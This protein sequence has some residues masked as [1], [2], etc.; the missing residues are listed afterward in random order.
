MRRTA[1]V[2]AFL[3]AA[4]PAAAA[5]VAP[6]QA[7]VPTCMGEPATIVGGR[8][9]DPLVG[10]P[11]RDVIVGG[12]GF[13]EIRGRGGDDLICG[14]RGRDTLY[15]GAG[16][17]VI[18]VGPADGSFADLVSYKTAGRGIHADLR[19][20]VV[21]GQGRDRILG[22]QLEL[23]GSHHDDVLIGGPSTVAIV[24]LA[25]DD[26]INGTSG[27]DRLSGDH[28]RPTKQSGDDI[29]HGGGGDDD[30]TPGPGDDV[31]SGGTGNDTI[32]VAIDP[33]H[34]TGSDLLRGGP[35]RDS[36]IDVVGPDDR[37]DYLGGR[38]WDTL[39]LRT[40][41]PVD[42]GVTHP[43]GRMRLD[44]RWTTDGDRHAE[45][46]VDNLNHVVLPGGGWRL[47]G[48]DRSEAL[49]AGWDDTLGR[50]VT[51]VG[52]GGDDNIIGTEYDDVLRGGG[53]HDRACGQGGQDE[54]EA[55][56]QAVHSE[57]LCEATTR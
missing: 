25:G 14:G 8:S 17:D 50:G 43:S 41:F 7:A 54:I 45:G 4:I 11:G 3:L 10:T 12:A 55:E 23:H 37:D 52:R 39:I 22:E 57:D 51:I 9:G 33:Y 24:G 48:T 26:R 5:V 16:N 19:S 32:G 29:I 56:E 53:G 42:G 20:G 34:P 35:G 49:W 18:H 44:G 36:I 1:L 30:I 38:G 40:H 28:F 21:T 6:A 46:R 31:V 47:V 2:T 27:D 13:D 15:G